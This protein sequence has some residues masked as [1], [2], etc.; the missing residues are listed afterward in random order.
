MFFGVYG[1]NENSQIQERGNL[2]E[3]LSDTIAISTSTQETNLACKT[4]RTGKLDIVESYDEIIINDKQLFT[5]GI[6]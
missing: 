4:C 5:N 1:Q 6:V 3:N 2:M